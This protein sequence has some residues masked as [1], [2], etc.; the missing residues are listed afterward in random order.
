MINIQK[1][2]HESGVHI[3]KDGHKVSRFA[4]SIRDLSDHVF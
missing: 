2:V 1:E 3:R 4:E